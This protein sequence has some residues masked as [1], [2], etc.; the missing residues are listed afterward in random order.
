MERLHASVLPHLTREFH[1]HDIVEILLRRR[2]PLVPSTGTHLASE[3]GAGEED[4][5]EDMEM[6]S[7]TLAS[8]MATL[9]LIL[10]AMPP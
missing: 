4:A 8:L 2:M 5:D 10:L 7:D 1:N 3:E 9:I 6:H